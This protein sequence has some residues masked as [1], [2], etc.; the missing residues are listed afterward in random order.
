MQTFEGLM[1]FTYKVWHSEQDKWAA[2]KEAG[3]ALEDDEIT[4]AHEMLEK[5]ISINYEME[6][7]IDASVVMLK[8]SLR[9]VIIVLDTHLG[10]E[11]A[12]R[13]LASCLVRINSIDPDLCFIAEP[14]AQSKEAAR[15]SLLSQLDLLSTG[16]GEL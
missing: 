4:I 3:R 5:M 15:P 6:E 13:S 2:K 8:P 14:L 9:G 10:E 11:E 16:S 12:D 7:E 1:R